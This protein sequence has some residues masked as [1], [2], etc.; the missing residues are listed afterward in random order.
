MLSH[1][2]IWSSQEPPLCRWEH[3]GSERLNN[4]PKV[5]QPLRDRCGRQSSHPCSTNS[6]VQDGHFT[7]EKMIGQEEED[8]VKEGVRRRGEMKHPEMERRQME[9]LLAVF[10]IFWKTGP[11]SLSHERVWSRELE[12][13]RRDLKG[14]PGECKVTQY[15]QPRVLERGFGVR[16]TWFKS[17]LWYTWTVQL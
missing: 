7:H 6:H 3:W 10:M 11:S 16:C 1:Y 14:S 5:T 13:W 15:R 17:Q 2:P 8:K 12:E 9:P 4:M